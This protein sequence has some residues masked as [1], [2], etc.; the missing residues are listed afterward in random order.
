[1]STATP[2]LMLQDEAQR[3]IGLTQAEGFGLEFVGIHAA[4]R[5]VAIAQI[6]EVQI[7]HCVEGAVRS[8][9]TDVDDPLLFR[10]AGRRG[11]QQGVGGRED[12]R[13][14]ADADGQRGDGGQREQRLPGEQPK[15]MTKMAGHDG[16]YAAPPPR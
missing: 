8:R 11:E 1:M 9:E 4:E 13:V 2:C 10:D 7:R 12:G 6:G 16:Y 15:G 14:G 3:A 5:A